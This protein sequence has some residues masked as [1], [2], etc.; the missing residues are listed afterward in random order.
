[1]IDLTTMVVVN[2]MYSSIMVLQYLDNTK[3]VLND[4][5]DLNQGF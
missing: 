4:I 1:M 3:L 2:S 5:R